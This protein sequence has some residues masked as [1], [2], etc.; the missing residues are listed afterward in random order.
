M[1]ALVKKPHIELSIHGEDTE[2]LLNWIR[3]KF[4]VDI[5]TFDDP[6]SI[7]IETTEFWEE[8]QINKTGNLLTAARLKA[9]MT[10]AELAQKM[11]ITQNMISDDETGKRNISR[12]MAKR[13]SDILEISSSR[14]V[15]D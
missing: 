9:E 1:L 12:K 14:L 11:E 10:Q 2:E 13:F 7:P 4:E 3:K 5:L 8:M 15:P 6:D